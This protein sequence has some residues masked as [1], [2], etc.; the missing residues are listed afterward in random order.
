MTEVLPT[1]LNSLRSTLGMVYADG[2]YDTK[3]CNTLVRYKGVTVCIFSRKNRDS[4]RG[5]IRIT[6]RCWSCT[7]KGNRDAQYL[8]GERY[9]QGRGVAKR[10]DHAQRGNGK[11]AAQQQPDA[12]LLQAKQSDPADAFI[13]YQPAANAG[14]A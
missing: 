2:A 1:L 9:E 11:A 7:R 4:G 12:L 5:D 13:A 6:M 10:S 8:P 14:S 3:A